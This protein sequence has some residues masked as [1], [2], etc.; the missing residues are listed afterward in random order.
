MKKLMLAALLL[1]SMPSFAHKID[2]AKVPAAVKRTFHN[3]FP[4]VKEGN[5][6][7]EKGSY[8]ITFMQ[9]GQKVSVTYDKNG[10]WME[11]ERRISIKALPPA[12][13]TYIDQNCDG[14]LVHAA[15][16]IKKANGETS[17]EARVKRQDYIFDADGKFV[18]IEKD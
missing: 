10:A 12:A 9:N 18:K 5:W 15:F 16:V 3:D 14:N 7:K 17:Y 11:T 4:E 1:G 8:E 6:E 13:N 2:H